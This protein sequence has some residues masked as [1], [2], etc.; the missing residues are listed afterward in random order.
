MSEFNLTMTI[1]DNMK[2]YMNK[3][4]IRNSVSGFVVMRRLTSLTFGLCLVFSSLVAQDGAAGGTAAGEALFKAN[5]QTCHRILEDFTGP[6]LKDAE[7]RV[8]GGRAWIYEWVRNSNGVISKG[9]KYAIDLFKKWNNTPMT[10]YPNFTNEQIDQI[11]DYVAAY[12]PKV[13]STAT[14]S[15]PDPKLNSIWNWVRILMVVVVLLLFNIAILVSRARG[16]D[17]LKGLNVQATNAWGLLLFYF[18]LQAGSIWLS[19]KYVSRFHLVLNPAS[20]HGVDI[21][22]MFWITMAVSYFVF[23]VVNFFLFYFGWKYGKGG[24][25]KATYYPEN[26]K[27]ELLWTVVPALVLTALITFGIITWN[28]IMVH[29]PD[30]N[31]YNVELNAQQFGWNLHYPGVDNKLGDVDVHLISAD[32]FLG[33]NFS[34]AVSHDDFVANEIYLPK[35][36]PVTLTIR[37]RDVIHAVHMPHFR[38]K[39]DAV[40]GMRTRFTFVPTKTTA[41]YRIEKN[42]PEFDYELACAEVCGK[43]HFAMQ[44]KIIVVEEAEYL[45]WL[46]KQPLM[47]KAELHSIKGLSPEVHQASIETKTNTQ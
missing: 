18:A 8:P 46:K 43:G 44:K 4:S 45:A 39:M 2:S 21:D 15:A 31:A 27:L 22:R 16:V 32:N 23:V 24:P 41:E 42:N 34:E 17:V 5:C 3:Q 26:H 25:K 30:L 40:P 33:V 9:D 29:D 35:G 10:A 37:S 28:R 20:E 38:V 19:F 36:K 11:L 1:T 47:Y 13:A 6:M 12:K 7:N 14:T